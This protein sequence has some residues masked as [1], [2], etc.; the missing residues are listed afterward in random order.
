MDIQI[1][2]SAPQAPFDQLRLQIIA[3]VRGGQLIAGTKIPTV[4]ALA[5]EIGLAPNTVAKAYRELAEAGVIETR[6]KQGTFIASAGDPTRAR[7]ERA[8]TELVRDLRAL[9]LRDSE[10]LDLVAAALRGA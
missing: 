5:A 6:G 8:A 9:G 4:R 1:D 3:Q 7:A 2:P 10:V